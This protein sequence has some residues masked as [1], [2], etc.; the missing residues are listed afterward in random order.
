[1]PTFSFSAA[2]LC[3]LGA[4][5]VM[6]VPVSMTGVK[7]DPVPSPN[8]NW[9]GDV[10]ES[11]AVGKTVTPGR[12]YHLCV[13]NKKLRWN[14]RAMDNS[15]MSIFNGTDFFQLTADT[16]APGGWT[17]KTKTSGPVSSQ[18]YISISFLCF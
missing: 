12:K 5:A 18:I 11:L 7:D 17:C 1:M 10:V 2:A 3:A 15:T 16:T 14:Q 6:A 8:G 13:D 9:C 4:S